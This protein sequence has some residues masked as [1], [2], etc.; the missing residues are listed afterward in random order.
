MYALLQRYIRRDFRE[1]LCLEDFYEMEG[2]HVLL[3]D[4]E[5]I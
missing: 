4:T 5:K 1:V 3:L 2:G